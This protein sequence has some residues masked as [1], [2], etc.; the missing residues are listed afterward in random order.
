MDLYLGIDA[1]GTHTRARLVTASPGCDRHAFY[2]S[3][4][5]RVMPDSGVAQG[6]A[7]GGMTESGD[8]SE[9]VPK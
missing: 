4:H 1:G 6:G 8:A 5:D 7:G 3:S 9:S 2:Y